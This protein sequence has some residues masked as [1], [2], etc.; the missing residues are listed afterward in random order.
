[1]TAVWTSC[2]GIN[3]KKRIHLMPVFGVTDEMLFE[4]VPMQMS[5]FRKYLNFWRSAVPAH[6]L[7]TAMYNHANELWGGT[8]FYDIPIVI[9]YIF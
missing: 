7:D 6:L 9:I 8:V 4:S 5:R 2:A 1:M 3:L